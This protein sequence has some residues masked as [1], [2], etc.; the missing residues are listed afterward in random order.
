MNST[1]A[2]LCQKTDSRIAYESSRQQCSLTRLGNFFVL[3]FDARSDVTA[4]HKWGRK[5]GRFLDL[6]FFI[7]YNPNNFCDFALT[8]RL[9]LCPRD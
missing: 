6:S 3:T 4:W 1:C 2:D 5:W 8:S 9:R 7:F